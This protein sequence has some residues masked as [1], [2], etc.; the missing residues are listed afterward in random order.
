MAE[1]RGAEMTDVNLCGQLHKLTS[2]EGFG[3]DLGD[4]STYADGKE[5]PD[6]GAFLHQAI[7]PEF[8]YVATRTPLRFSEKGIGVF[9]QWVVTAILNREQRWEIKAL[10]EALEFD[11]ADELRRTNRDVEAALVIL[12]G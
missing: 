9:R 10:A 2:D 1:S 3:V 4:F 6:V 12:R 5:S 11:L 8:G 7:K